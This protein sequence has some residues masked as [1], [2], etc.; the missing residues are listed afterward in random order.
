[1]VDLLVGVKEL[2]QRVSG[3]TLE[4]FEPRAPVSNVDSCLTKGAQVGMHEQTS[5]CL[6]GSIQGNGFTGHV[7]V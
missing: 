2:E 5:S 4:R 1:M 3:S 6:D 7:W